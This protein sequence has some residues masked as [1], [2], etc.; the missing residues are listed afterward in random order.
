MSLARAERA[1]LCATLD[2]TDPA[3]PTLCGD[4]TTRDLLAHLLV[5]ERQPWS[6]VGVVVPALAG[7]TDRA[8]RGYAGTPWPELVDLLRSGPPDDR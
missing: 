4:W 1:A 8:M 6:A 5:R 3:Q 2:H 7:V